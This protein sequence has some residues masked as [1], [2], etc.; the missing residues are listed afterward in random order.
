MLRGIAG[1]LPLQ[2]GKIEIASGTRI[3]FLPQRRNLDLAVPISVE[4]MVAMGLWE[5]IGPFGQVSAGHKRRIAQALGAVKLAAGDRRPL[6]RLSGG[7]LQRVLFARLM[8]QNADLILLDEPFRAIDSRT[9]EDLLAVLAQWHAE[10]RTVLAALHDLEIVRAR[11]PSAMLLARELLAHGA[12][13]EVATDANLERARQ[14]SIEFDEKADEC[15]RES[16]R[17]AA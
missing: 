11:F 7:V 14:I 2:G 16:E 6:A 12:S 1:Q 10:G 9:V 5:E 4:D 8:L 13:N 17:A 15:E 3:A